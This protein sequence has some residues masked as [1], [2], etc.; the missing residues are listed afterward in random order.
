MRQTLVGL[1]LKVREKIMQMFGEIHEKQTKGE[2]VVE[3]F[4]KY[5]GK[6]LYCLFSLHIL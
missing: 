2:G 3:L 1:S 4:S 5:F 6:C